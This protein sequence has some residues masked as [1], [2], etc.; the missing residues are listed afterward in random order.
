MVG[1]MHKRRFVCSLWGVESV[2][3]QVCVHAP[4]CWWSLQWGASLPVRGVI[5]VMWGMSVGVCVCCGVVGTGTLPRGRAK[6][7]MLTRKMGEESALA[8]REQGTALAK[9]WRQEEAAGSA[10]GLER[11]PGRLGDGEGET[12]MWGRQ[13]RPSSVS[14]RVCVWWR[15]EE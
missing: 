15:A 12:G 7:G 8:R 3:V 11:V 1:V 4:L 10:R 9:A 2:S 14:W 13:G 5:C 6:G